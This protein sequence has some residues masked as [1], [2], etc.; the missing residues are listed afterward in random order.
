M[1]LIFLRDHLSEY[2]RLDLGE[3]SNT[4]TLGFEVNKD[5]ILLHTDAACFQIRN[6]I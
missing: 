6:G 5:G 4:L 3:A 1:A 2:D